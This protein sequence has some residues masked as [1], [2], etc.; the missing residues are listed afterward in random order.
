MSRAVLVLILIAAPTLAHAGGYVSAGIGGGAELGGELH[1]LSGEGHNAGRLALGR[2]FGP[3]ALEG[4]V[5]GFG[6]T[7]T[8]PGGAAVD[9]EALSTSLSGKAHAGL[10]AGL[11]AF[12]RVGVMR[13]WIRTDSMEDLEGDGYVIG[14]GLD[15]R[16]SLPVWEAALWLELD[17]EFLD[18]SQGPA[19]YQ[20]TADT[21]L[22]GV[23]IGI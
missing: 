17:R 1:N 22:A 19:R 12:V 2:W 18:L 21:L 11:G 13:T 4:A 20:G 16:I 7:G 23:R 3:I 14:A 9:G 5:S 10:I 8:M 6:V 15:Y